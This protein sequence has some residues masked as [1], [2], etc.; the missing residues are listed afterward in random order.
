MTVNNSVITKKTMLPLGLVVSV[1]VIA[2]SVL[3]WADAEHDSLHTMCMTEN[4]S[5]RSDVHNDIVELK[6]QVQQVDMKIDGLKDLL[7]QWNG[8]TP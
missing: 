4:D 6:Q 7:I 1:V 5:L 3:L 8:G 2:V